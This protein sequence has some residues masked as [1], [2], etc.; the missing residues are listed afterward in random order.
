MTNYAPL[1]SVI[2]PVYNCENYVGEAIDSVLNQPY[3]NIRI[4]LVDD[5][6]W[7]SS[8]EICDRY[9]S[10]NE[11]VH[12]IHQQN[13]GVSK[14]RNTGIDYVLAHFTDTDYIAFLDADDK[15]CA[16]FLSVD[17]ITILKRGID[18]L[19]FQSYNANNTLT[20]SAHTKALIEGL[21][22]GGHANVWLHASQ[23]FASML[24][25]ADLL[26]SYHLRFKEQLKYGEDVIFRMQCIY[27]AKNMQLINH[28]LY[29]YRRSA[30]SAVHTRKY[31]ISYFTPIIDSWID[32][33]SSMASFESETRA[34]LWEGRAMAAVCIVDMI[35]EH[36]QT[37]GHVSTL[38]QLLQDKPEYEE[39]ITSPFAYNRPDSGL[40]WQKM[41]AHPVRFRLQ[42]YARGIISSTVRTLYLFLMRIPLIAKL[43]DKKRYPIAI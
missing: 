23:S 41:Q 28:P 22:S 8:P 10:Q 34:P 32:S 43:L 9:A 12:V 27:L 40:R 14:A 33:D 31:G 1:I 18:L 38:I 2:I 15:W 6:S 37:F 36:F 3:G 25:A 21:Y 19:G 5:G 20:R 11:R 4:V 39:L 17:I 16:G 24:Y 30:S 13:S 42:C 7:D 26:R 29:L 35:C